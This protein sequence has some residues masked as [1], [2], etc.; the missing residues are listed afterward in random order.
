[1]K[2]RASQSQTV[3]PTKH[4]DAK[5]VLPSEIPDRLFDPDSMTP[6]GI[7]FSCGLAVGAS[8]A[9]AFAL[10]LGGQDWTIYWMP[11]ALGCF[12]LYVFRIDE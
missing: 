10:A 9:S 11:A 12:A 2:Q 5:S 8:F 6:K 4:E 3:H 1:M 7:G